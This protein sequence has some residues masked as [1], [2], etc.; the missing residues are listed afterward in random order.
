MVLL[1]DFAGDAF[2]MWK[3]GE[4]PNVTGFEVSRSM[5]TNVWYYVGVLQ[6]Y[7]F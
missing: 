6:T 4:S 2:Y 3:L 1:T 5:G 7:L